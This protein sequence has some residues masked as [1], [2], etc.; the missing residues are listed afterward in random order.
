M[1][2]NGA[3]L[4]A[5]ER[6]LKL[7]HVF[8]QRFYITLFDAINAD[9]LDRRFG[10]VRHLAKPQRTCKTSTALER[11]QSPQNLTP[12]TTLLWM[13]DP[14]AHGSAQLRQQFLRFFLKDRAQVGIHCIGNVDVVRD[15]HTRRVWRRR[16]HMHESRL[17]RGLTSRHSHCHWGR[18]GLGHAFRLP[19]SRGR[20]H[21]L[22]TPKHFQAGRLQDARCK[23]M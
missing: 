22:H 16:G 20:L 3:S 6:D 5:L 17:E 4:Q 15:V 18:H 1:N 14:F 11:M 7:V 12:W 13:G 2:A 21:G 19:L 8:E 10:T 9:G 23:L